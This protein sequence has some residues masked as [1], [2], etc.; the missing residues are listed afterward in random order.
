MKVEE[1]RW[2]YGNDVR[3]A[4]AV[5]VIRVLETRLLSRERI[6]QAADA[7][8]VEE[9][10]R[11]LAETSYSEH[12]SSL[13]D[14]RDY[15]SFLIK[16]RQKA[17]DLVQKLTK[18]PQLTDLLLYRFDFHNLKVALK[19][20]LGEQDLRAAYVSFG[21][22]PVS[23]IKA[24]VKEEDLSSLPPPFRQVAE[25]AM[26]GFPDRQE[27]KWIDLVIDREMYELLLSRSRREGS[28]F[29]YDLIR[30]EID[31][32]N[33]LSL[34]RIRRSG[35]KRGSFRESFVEGGSLSGEF[36]LPLLDE[37]LEALSGRF[38]H[39]PYREVV[40]NGW[41]EL[42]ANG[43][44][45]GFERMS[46]ELIL[47]YLRKANLIAFGV[48]PLIAYVQ[49]KENELGMLRTILVGKL[50]RLEPRL[51]KERLPHVYL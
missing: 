39:T 35:Q 26:R 15:E 32:I 4:Y 12:L 20:K 46:R 21:S 50:N 18:D 30:R 8:D 29:L 47:E 43:S 16:E 24:A 38:V 34:F 48:E 13:T 51:I 28:L 44:F 22:V 9:V 36:F 17:L 3:Y 11:I 27:P 49:A 41:E 5:G 19:E 7:S 40:E 42:S 31:L 2:K 1:I 45:A 25:K 6:D 23:M 10:L 37:P 14:P 33:I